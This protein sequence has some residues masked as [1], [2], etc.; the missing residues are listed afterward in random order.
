M[1]RVSILTD[2]IQYSCVLAYTLGQCIGTSR[3]RTRTHTQID[4]RVLQTAVGCMGVQAYTSS[5]K[6][7]TEARTNHYPESQSH[8][9]QVSRPASRFHLHADQVMYTLYIINAGTVRFS[10]ECIYSTARF[11]CGCSTLGCLAR[12][13]KFQGPSFCNYLFLFFSW[14]FG[15]HH[16]FHCYTFCNK[17]AS[18]G[19]NWGHGLLPISKFV[20]VAAAA[21]NI[22]SAQNTHRTSYKRF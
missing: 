3:T 8:V 22:A 17:P 11:N 18:M 20:V 9:Y 5:R 19:S 14:T 16:C 2:Y 13:P 4:R 15:L 10:T 12:V 1:L 21:T 7:R 6:L